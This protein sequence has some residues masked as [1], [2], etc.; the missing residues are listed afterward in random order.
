MVEFTN[1]LRRLPTDTDNHEENRL[2][3][4]RNEQ[5][6]NRIESLRAQYE[7][8]VPQ[9]LQTRFLI[10]G[11]IKPDGIDDMIITQMDNVDDE[12]WE[13]IQSAKFFF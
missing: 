12:L 4:W 13:R 8:I 5:V 1:N 10:D 3:L 2:N 6:D 9:E 11:V 7:T